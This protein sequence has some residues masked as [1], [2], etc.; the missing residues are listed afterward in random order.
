MTVIHPTL[1]K[2]GTATAYSIHPSWPICWKIAQKSAVL[3]PEVYGALEFHKQSCLKKR[4]VSRAFRSSTANI[5]IVPFITRTLSNRDG[6]PQ[7]YSRSE[8]TLI[9]LGGLSRLLKEI[10]LSLSLA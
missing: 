5:T 2:S 9:L 4:R 7:S 10:V 6:H 3:F 8:R 1:A